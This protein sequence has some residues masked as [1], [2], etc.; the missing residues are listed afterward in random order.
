MKL[1]PAA[2][3]VSAAMLFML[4]GCSKKKIMPEKFKAMST[5]MN[6]RTIK[7]NEYC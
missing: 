7:Y 1:R 6:M 2:L 3:A 5:N 4:P